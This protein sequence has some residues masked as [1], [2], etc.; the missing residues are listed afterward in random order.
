MTG[1]RAGERVFADGGCGSCHTLAAAGATGKVASNLDEREPSAGTAVRWVRDGGKGM[2]SF[3]R[4]LDRREIQ[5]VATFV[6]RSS[7]EH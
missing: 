3:A 6:A 2:P 5:Q 4:Q 1:A 7:R